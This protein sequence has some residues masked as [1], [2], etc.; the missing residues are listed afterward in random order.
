MSQ[1][2][3]TVYACIC[4]YAKEVKDYHASN[5]SSISSFK[6]LKW[7]RKWLDVFLQQLSAVITRKETGD[8][9][10]NR[11]LGAGFC[12]VQLASCQAGSQIT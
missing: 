1:S 2:Q 9:T 3:V 11:A 6:Y 4:T 5:N 10:E 12:A 7:Y 8:V